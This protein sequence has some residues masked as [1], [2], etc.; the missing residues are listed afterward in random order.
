[1]EIIGI[2]FPRIKAKQMLIHE[3]TVCE[4]EITGFKL[5]I[6]PMDHNSGTLDC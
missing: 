1:M 5:K 6:K 3:F 2:L 4:K